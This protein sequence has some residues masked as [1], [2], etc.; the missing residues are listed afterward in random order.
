[1]TANL[2]SPSACSAR[3]PQAAKHHCFISKLAYRGFCLCCIH[4]L[5]LSNLTFLV[6]HSHSSI[7]APFQIPSFDLSS[8]SMAKEGL[9][10]DFS[11]LIKLCIYIW[12]CPSPS[13]LN[14][15][16]S[17]CSLAQH[18]FCATS[19]C[20]VVSHCILPTFQFLL[21]NSATTHNVHP[22]PEAKFK[23][24]DGTCSHILWASFPLWL[25]PPQVSFYSFFK[26]FPGMP[27]YQSEN[28][29]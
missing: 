10:S 7:L 9:A 13:L 14:S 4:N 11:N 12:N 2:V 19:I 29:Y 26:C 3:F 22:P 27:P 15:L 16:Q 20:S 5:F 28:S 23:N 25:W 6:S 8:F 17:A 24:Y 1:M 18:T 21:P